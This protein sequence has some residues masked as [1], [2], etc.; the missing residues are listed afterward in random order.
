MLSQI[1]RTYDAVPPKVRKLVLRALLLFATWTLLY[2]YWLKPDGRLDDLLTKV[3]VHGSVALMQP[4][5]TNAYHVGPHLFID[6][7][8]VVNIAPQCNG[9]ELIVLYLGFLVCYST[10]MLRR[11]LFGL[12]GI[13]VITF[14]NMVRCVLL[15]WLYLSDV[16]LANFA[17]HFA[18]K[19]IIYGV[20][21]LGWVWYTKTSSGARKPVSA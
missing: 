6:G 4:F 19:L 18:F 5:F 21:F 16:D 17:H 3:V 8:N 11:V 15:A 2:Y 7:R 14:L 1:K 20:V 13:V 10:T 12:G 9:L